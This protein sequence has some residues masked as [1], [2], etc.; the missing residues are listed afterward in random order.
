ML[1]ILA[2]VAR[3]LPLPLKRRLHARQLVLS[4]KLAVLRR[5]SV[6]AWSRAGIHHLLLDHECANFTYDIANV[7]ELPQF[8]ASSVGC[9]V[10]DAGRYLREIVGDDALRR[11]LAARLR[12]RSDRNAEPRF[13]RRLGWYC[14]ARACRPGLIVETGTHD[15]LGTTL[16]LRAAELNAAEGTPTRVVTLDIEPGSG[17]LIPNDLKERLD[18]YIGD[19]HETLPRA[20][21]AHEVGMLIHD[22]EHTAERERFEFGVA[23][24]HA[25]STLVLISDNA[26]ATTALRDLAAEL[27]IAYHYFTE[28]PVHHFYPGAAIGLAVYRR[29]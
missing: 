5:Y 16:L 28:R 2:S 21:A 29:P 18:I 13:G 20:V 3:V 14:V 8:V 15:G 4:H 7:H 27:G 12:Q 23:L 9:S 19:T 10:D 6:P 25:A 1:E 24:D 11:D 26:H 17:W 22:S